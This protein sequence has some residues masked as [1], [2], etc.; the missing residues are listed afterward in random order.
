MRDH[1]Q[2]LRSGGR[3]VEEGLSE[4]RSGS[5]LYAVHFTDVEAGGD[6]VLVLLRVPAEVAPDVATA[7]VTRRLSD[8]AP[9]LPAHR[10]IYVNEGTCICDSCT[11]TPTRG[12]VADDESCPVHH[13]AP[14]S[15]PRRPPPT[16]RCRV[17][18]ALWH[19][20]ASGDWTLISKAC[21]KCCDNAPMGEQIE[22]F[23]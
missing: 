2:R 11:C 5:D 19:R 13:P 1:D 21:G 7:A 15:S 10:P 23:P 4:I 20:F 18:G 16:H 22:V 9:V 12:E 8:M 6:F 14:L 3:L 17:C